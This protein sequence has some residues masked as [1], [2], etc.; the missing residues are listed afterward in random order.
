MKNLK[1]TFCLSLLCIAMSGF[2]AQKQFQLQSPNGVL[3]VDISLGEQITYS[4]KHAGETVLLPSAVSM[5]LNDGKSF[6]VNSTW[7][8]AIR[9]QVNQTI[10][11]PFYKRSEIIDNYNEITLIFKENFELIF[12]AYNESMAYRFVSTGKNDFIVEN[13]QANFEF[14]TDSPAFIPYIRTGNWNLKLD[15]F[16]NSFE[17]IYAHHRLSEW[18]DKQYAFLPLVVERANGKKVC[19]TESDLENYPGMFLHNPDKQ[20]NLQAYFAHYPKRTERGG[21]NQLQHIIC[22]RENYIARCKAKMNFPW[23]IV[24][25]SSE[26]RELLD[27]DIVYKLASP[28]RIR[29]TSWITPGKAAW[30]WWN[31]WNLYNV[32]FK[33]RINNQT[34]KYYI[35]FASK[36]K[37]EYV[38]MDEGWSVAGADLFTIVP[39]INLEELVEYGKQRNVGIILW[40]GCYPFDVDM[41]KVCKH[42]SEMGVKGFKIDFMD[43]DD[44]WMADFH[45]RSAETAAK[46]RMLVNFHGTYKPTGLNRTYPNAIN[47]EG[48]FGLEQAKFSE[49]FQENQVVYDVTMPFIR[50]VA[51]PMDYTP[52]AMRNA[53]HENFRNVN[54][55]PMSLGTR[56]RQLAEYIVFDSPLTMLC[57]SPSNYEKEPECTGFIASVPTVWDNTLPLYGKISEYLVLARQKGKEWYIG[58]LNNW[59]ERSIELDLSF[60]ENAIY[61]AEIFQDGVNAGKVGSDYKKTVTTI[62]ID[63]KLKLTMAPGGG[64]AVKLF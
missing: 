16:E 46:Y 11:S 25:V 47:F 42:Y 8:K 34:Y 59:T 40:A 36:N 43:R 61:H 45:Y 26:D 35:D 14:G 7:T 48:V 15:V 41:E 39:E 2:S 32:D 52:G 54:S 5:Q 13:E 17:N 19:I 3:Q 10:A 56:C 62:S 12:R 44:Q 60:L 24:I 53:N 51:G 1:I 49:I 30:E 63:K 9:K 6:G 29:D 20:T 37:I 22:E 27:S 57:D 21:Y 23:R 4:V 55:E 58:G 18:N 38:I 31:D 64:F 33:T 28:S 50:Q